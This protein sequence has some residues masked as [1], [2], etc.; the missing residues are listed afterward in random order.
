MITGLT[1]FLAHPF[2]CSFEFMY[3]S[4]GILTGKLKTPEGYALI[5]MG[6]FVNHAYYDFDTF[7]IC[8][9]ASDFSVLCF[10]CSFV[11]GL[12]RFCLI[13]HLFPPPL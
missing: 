2:P 7:G 1:V 4:N 3:L 5:L 6:N 12:F 8:I 13:V 10:L 9:L 11:L